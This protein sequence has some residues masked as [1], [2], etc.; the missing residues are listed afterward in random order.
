MEAKSGWIW[1]HDFRDGSCKIHASYGFSDFYIKSYVEQYARLNPWLE[2]RD[3][4][5]KPS[6]VLTGRD[7]LKKQ[8]LAKTAFYTEWLQPQ[9]LCRRI[10]GVLSVDGDEITAFELIR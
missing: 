6:A 9:D 10:A 8:D 1:T 5:A 4:Y 3:A 2:D 7:I